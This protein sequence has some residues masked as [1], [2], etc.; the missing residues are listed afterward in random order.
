MSIVFGGYTQRELDAQYEQRTLVPDVAG[1]VNE[2]RRLSAQ[3]RARV[4]CRCDVPYGPGSGERLDVYFPSSGNAPVHLHFHGGA[5]RMLCKDDVAYPAPLLTARGAVYVAV[6]FPLAAEAPLS[7]MVAS[8]RRALAWTHRH[9]RELGGDEERIFLSGF[10]SGAHLAAMLL[11]DDG[12]RASACVPNDAV[13]GAVLIS[14]I[15]DL[16]PVRLSK[17]NDLLALDEAHV[18]ALSP[19]RLLPAGDGPTVTVL[20]GAGELNEFR[21]QSRSFAD[22]WAAAGNPAQAAEL[23]QR[24]HFDMASDLGEEGS[25]VFARIRDQMDLPETV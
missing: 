25:A 20:W 21:R 15:Y 7:E 10:S 5:W 9:A 12:W 22:A 13:R 23:P 19:I 4:A 6:G 18:R 3:A 11:A 2:W 16:E 1:Y 14:G 8:A 24:N 17:R